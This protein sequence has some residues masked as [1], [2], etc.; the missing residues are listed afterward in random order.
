MSAAGVSV[1]DIV[2]EGGG[3]GGVLRQTGNDGFFQNLCPDVLGV[4]ASATGVVVALV[5]VWLGEDQRGAASSTADDTG[6]LA[7]QFGC[8]AG[9]VAPLSLHRVQ[10]TLSRLPGFDTD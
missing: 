6:G 5:V 7:L 8:G 9:L 2:G 3:V 1:D 4:S 10:L